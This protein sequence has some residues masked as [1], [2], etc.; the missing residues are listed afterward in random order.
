M[1]AVSGSWP[2]RAAGPGSGF[3]R[4]PSPVSARSA[5]GA[6]SPP[7]AR[8]ATG[9][10]CCSRS[11]RAWS[12]IWRPVSAVVRGS[13]RCSSHGRPRPR[14]QRVG[15]SRLPW[16]RSGCRARP[17]GRS[18]PIPARSAG[19]RP[20]PGRPSPRPSSN[21]R[22]GCPTP[23][24]SSASS[25]PGAGWR[26]RPEMPARRSPRSP[27][28][29]RR[30]DR[31]ST[32]AWSPAGASRTCIR[33]SPRGCRSATRSSTSATRRTPIPN[34]GSPSRSGRSPTTARSTPSGRTAPRSTGA[35]PIRSAPPGRRPAGWSSPARSSPSTAPTRCRLTRRSSCS[36]SPAG[37][38]RRRS[39]RSSRKRRRSGP[40]AT[41]WPVR[42]PAGPPGSSRRG[43][44][45][46]RSCSATGGGSGR[47]SI[48]TG[49]DRS[50]SQ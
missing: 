33:T 6:H 32:R 11:S 10:G 1:R 30:A 43:T 17:G 47:W 34:G 35:P 5:I 44:A 2:M 42:S 36:R 28:R 3:C 16:P 9:P 15:S 50:R 19:K 25:S 26:T 18:R 29:R 48:G 27:F 21:G 7:T 49:S 45:R 39:S 41:R 14:R 31:S 22:A 23:G 24:S 37:A 8:R 20:R 12:P 4:S 46:P 38:S 40:P 13:S